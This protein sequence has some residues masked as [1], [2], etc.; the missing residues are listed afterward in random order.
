[1]PVAD[2]FRP[3]ARACGPSN[4]GKRRHPAGLRNRLLS[5]VCSISCVFGIANAIALRQARGQEATIAD[6]TVGAQ[7]GELTKQEQKV[8]LETPRSAAIINGEKAEDQRLDRLD[9]FALRVP[10]YRPNTGNP[11]TSLPAIRG[12]GSGRVLQ[13]GGESDTGF[14]QDNVF[15]KYVGF[16]WGDYVDLDSFEIGLGPQGTTGGK[17]TTVGTVGVRTQLPSFDRKATFETSYANYSRIIEKVNLTGPIIDEKLAY[18]VA[19][20]LDQG[21]GWIHDQATGAGYLNNHRWGVRGQLLYVGDEFTDR[22]IFNRASSYEYNNYGK[23]GRGPFSDS[24]VLYANG[25]FGTN[26]SQ[27]LWN[28]LGRPV[29]T[30]DPYKPYVVGFGTHEA[31]TLSVSNEID[32]QIGENTLTSISAWGQYYTH[33]NSPETPAGGSQGTETNNGYGNIWVD[34]YSQ[35]LRLASPKDRQLEWQTGIYSLYEKLWDF[36]GNNFGT[37]AAKWYNNAALQRGFQQR[38]TGKSNTFQLAAFGQASY[39]LDD[40][41]TLTL[42]LRDSYEV[43]EG[44]NFA[45][46]NAASTTYSAQQVYSAVRGATGAGIFDTGGQTK[47]RNMFTGIFNPKYKVDDNITLYGLLGRGEKAGAINISALPIMD[48]LTFKGFQPVITKPETSWDYEIGAKTSWLDGHLIANMNLYWSDIFNLQDQLTDTSYLDSTGQPLRLTYLGNIPHIRLR[49]VEFDGRWSPIERLQLNLSGA[50]TEVRYIDFANAAPPSDWIWPTPNPVPAGFIK[51]PLTLS[52]SNTRW[53]NLPKWAF[54]VGAD[55]EHPLGPILSDLGPS[56]AVPVNGFAYVNVAWK[57]RTQLTDPHSVFQYWQAAYSL[58]DFG[59]GLR[60]EDKRYSLSVW[61]KNL[62]DKRYF[63]SW[64]AGTTT[65]PA[66]V[67]LQDL[68]RTFGGTLRVTLD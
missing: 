13:I 22:L 37:D 17:N 54:N 39:H 12:M 20:Y 18:R 23:S 61:S 8:L 65:A 48:G 57:D 51:A 26:F 59:F 42:G 52:R 50:Y 9:D 10:N 28:R 66:T 49:G 16:Q 32:R 30:F 33:P 63:T 67:G 55:Y 4:A 38:Q 68:P 60:T 46:I 3:R 34:Q 14:V 25:T 11:E 36:S 44:S 41:W 35:E 47:K 6:V 15:W 53:E 7:R 24:A 19:F 40:R 29:L 56:W 31:Q 27:T 45:W 58:V 64:T 5:S 62:F 21:D 43:K 2:R 1:M